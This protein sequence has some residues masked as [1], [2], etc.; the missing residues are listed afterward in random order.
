MLVDIQKIFKVNLIIETHSEYL[1]RK[2]QYLTATKEFKP[3]DAVIYYFNNPK[4]VRE[5][6][7]QIKKITIDE[8]G[9]LSDHFGPGFIDEGTNVKFELL[10]Y[11]KSRNN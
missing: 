11:N 2:L 4:K 6:E 3:G 7:E 5:G 10:R 1:I 9:S 8:N